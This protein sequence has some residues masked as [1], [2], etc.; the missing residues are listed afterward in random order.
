[1]ERNKNLG[2]VLLFVFVGL[3]LG[4]VLGEGLGYL[5]GKLGEMS[6]GSFDNPIRSFFVRSMDIDLGFDQNGWAVD[7][8]LV[9][10]RFGLGFKFNI[11]SVGGMLVGL[12]MMKWWRS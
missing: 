12:Y 2:F 5:L 9:K 4:G 1:M 11:C 3:I 8:Y 10:L 6:G 7:L